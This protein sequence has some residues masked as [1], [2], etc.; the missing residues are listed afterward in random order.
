LP[1]KNEFWQKSSCFM[2]TNSQKTRLP[3]PQVLANAALLIFVA[4]VSNQIAALLRVTRVSG[5][6]ACR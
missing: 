5:G 1:A 3:A 2:L 4:M 6:L